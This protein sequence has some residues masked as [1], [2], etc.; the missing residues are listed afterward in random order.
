M[1]KTNG[2]RLRIQICLLANRE[3]SGHGVE[4]GGQ[5]SGRGGRCRGNWARIP[6][7]AS[8]SCDQGITAHNDIDRGCVVELEL[9]LKVRMAEERT[10]G[11]R[12]RSHVF[13]KNKRFIRFSSDGGIHEQIKIKSRVGRGRP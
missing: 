5:R 4:D 11:G 3:L 8:T 10:R 1:T 6:P 2:Y 12:G 9:G 13:I 7:D